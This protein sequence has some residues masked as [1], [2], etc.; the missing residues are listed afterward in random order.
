MEEKEGILTGD[1]LERTKRWEMCICHSGGEF[2]AVWQKGGNER[3]V[4]GAGKA[5]EF[6]Y[7]VGNFKRAQ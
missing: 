7:G 4:G 2:G 5:E 3:R 1:A 6:L